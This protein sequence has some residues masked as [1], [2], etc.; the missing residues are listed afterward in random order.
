[1]LHL[2]LKNLWKQKLKS[3]EETPILQEPKVKEEKGYD[4]WNPLLKV[5]RIL[6]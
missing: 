3:K 4:N 6:T 2:N 1:M 5:K